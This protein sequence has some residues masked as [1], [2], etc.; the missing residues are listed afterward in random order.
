MFILYQN[1]QEEYFPNISPVQLFIGNSIAVDNT[2]C[3]SF[4]TISTLYG[5]SFTANQI[6]YSVGTAGGLGLS[7][8]QLKYNVFVYVS[9]STFQN[10]TAWSA[11]G[12][13]IDIF[14]RVRGSNV[15]FDN[16][17]F[18]SNGF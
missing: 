16:C 2:C 5:S 14:S 4:T 6:G 17:S 10:N 18:L 15:M 13:H 1:F 8:A 11:A 9:S 3:A 12:A 7:L